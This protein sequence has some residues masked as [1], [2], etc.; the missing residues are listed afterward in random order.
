MIA[1][2]EAKAVNLVV[3]ELEQEGLVHGITRVS[4]D[5]GRDSTDDSAAWIKLSIGGKK[6]P[7]EIAALHLFSLTCK[8][9]VF[10]AGL[11]MWA[12]VDFV[13]N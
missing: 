8:K 12:Y 5:F 7:S 4:I 6:N 3:K 1:E 2:N 10:E 13:N 11:T 9:K